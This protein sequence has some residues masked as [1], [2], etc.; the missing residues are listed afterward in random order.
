MKRAFRVGAC[1]PCAIVL[2]ACGGGGGSN[3]TG[4]PPPP[5]ANYNLQAGIANM[6]AHG[7]TANVTLSGTVTVN[8]TSVPFTGTGTYTL[9][10]AVNAMFNNAGAQAQTQ[11]IS[12]TVN[13]A[14]QSQAISISVTDYYATADSSF[15]GE[16]GGNEYDV[17]QAPFQYP[18]AVTGASSGTLG[19][20]LRYTDSTQSVSLGTAQVTY[21]TLTPVD[22][23]SPMGITITTS[24]QQETDV[25]KYTM[26]AANVI[27]FVSASAQNAQGTLT[28]TAQ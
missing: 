15:L 14:G 5:A 8:G 28:V 18:T 2:V 21:Q 27:S 22:P 17:A 24:S 3:G 1:L 9:T 6:V 20:V 4:S 23:G 26:T 16:A 19:T 12:G 25:T 11:T 13:A 7:L 10:P